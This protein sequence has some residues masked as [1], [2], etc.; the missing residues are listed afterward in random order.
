MNNY[1]RFQFKNWKLEPKSWE[2]DS[3]EK[4]SNPDG[5]FESS[6]HI[7][8]IKVSWQSKWNKIGGCIEQ[9]WSNHNSSEILMRNEMKKYSDTTAS[10]VNLVAVYLSTR[11]HP[12]LNSSSALA[13]FFFFYIYIQVTFSQ[14]AARQIRSS[15]QQIGGRRAIAAFYGVWGDKNSIKI[16][17]I[18]LNTRKSSTFL[19]TCLQNVRSSWHNGSMLLEPRRPA[20]CVVTLSWFLTL[21][22][23]HDGNEKIVKKT[24]TNYLF[25]L[26]FLVADLTTMRNCVK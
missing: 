3:V 26:F 22:I 8:S 5:F 25:A 13:S 7:N 4:P 12:G 15:P 14:M 18:L 1:F 17:T 24:R 11:F 16:V 2:S 10:H 20:F 23:F 19:K 21:G 9:N 6:R